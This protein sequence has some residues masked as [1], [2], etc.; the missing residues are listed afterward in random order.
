MFIL[1]C[2]YLFGP[3]LEA[4]RT[5]LMEQLNVRPAAIGNVR[6]DAEGRAN[7]GE[8]DAEVDNVLDV[9]AEVDGDERGAVGPVLPVA[10]EGVSELEIEE[11]HVG[12]DGPVGV[13][14]EVAVGEVI[15]LLDSEDEQNAQVVVDQEN[16]IAEV[17]LPPAGNYLAE[18][19]LDANGEGS[20]VDQNDAE[21]D[22][23]A[24][25][26]E[27]MDARRGV[28]HG[29]GPVAPL[30]QGALCAV[31][32]KVSRWGPNFRRHFRTVHP[33]LPIPAAP[34]RVPYLRKA[35]RR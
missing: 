29:V 9:V 3:K 8:A 13:D 5:L 19:E 6:G 33:A 17:V 31:C 30:E 21:N 7:G 1:V 24:L 35:D 10:A 27:R 2:L 20:D 32:G 15:D 18:E 12:P 22:P 34:S 23:L 4:D 25:V 14:G 26:A 16:A 11:L 28:R